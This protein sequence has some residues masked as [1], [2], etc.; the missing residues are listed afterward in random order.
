MCNV[1]STYIVVS[2]FL[3]DPLHCVLW[4][5]SCNIQPCSVLLLGIVFDSLEGDDLEYTLR[6]RHEVGETDT[7]HTGEAAFWFQYPGARVTDK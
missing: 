7:W 4:Y 3:C 5:V 6:L 2:L 1:C